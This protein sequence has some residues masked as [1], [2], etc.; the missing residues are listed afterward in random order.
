MSQVDYTAISYG[1]LKRYFLK[2]CG[3]KAALQAYLDRR[4][5]RSNSII[6]KVEIR[7]SILRLRQP[8]ASK[9][10]NIKVSLQSA[11]LD[12]SLCRIGFNCRLLSTR[13]LTCP[14]FQVGT[15]KSS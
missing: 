1:E 14:K 4:K 12:E 2:N 9:C 5:K 6:K 3:N 10:K 8:F 11:H 7:I 13:F 15:E